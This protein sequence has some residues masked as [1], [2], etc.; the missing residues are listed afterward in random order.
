[1][2]TPDFAVPFLEALTEDQFFDVIGVITQ[3]DKLAGRKQTLSQ[4]PIKIF[5]AKHG[6]PVYQPEEIASLE[7][8]IKNLAPGLIIVAAYGQIL[9]QSILDISRYGCINVHASLLPKYRGAAPIQAAI[10]N[11][12]EKTGVS[13]MKMEAGL[14]TGPVLG[15]NIV[16]VRATDTA[17]SL[18]N[19]LVDCGLEIF[20][21]TLKKYVQGEVRPE[22]QDSRQATYARTLKKSDAEIDWAKSA[23]E[24][25]RMI[26]AYNPWPG[27]RF[28]ISPSRHRLAEADDSRPASPAYRSGRTTGG[29]TI[30]ILE[31]EFEPVKMNNYTPGA[32]FAYKN[33]LAVQC[34]KDA[35]IIKKIQPAGKKPMSGEEFLNGY[36]DKLK[37]SEASSSI[38]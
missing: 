6:L 20:I 34:G 29:L 12:D 2:G 8:E 37:I 26:R 28:T 17:L 24:I 32:L 3:P 10:L 31:T 13:I 15:Q 16:K 23:D 33:K 14:D 19:K 11:G 22:P 25:E 7:S 35:L 18:F 38:G 5:S 30:K 36:K 21:P 1:M 9:P 4:S 27:S